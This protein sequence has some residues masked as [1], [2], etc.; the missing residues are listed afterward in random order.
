MLAYAEWELLT[1]FAAFLG[2]AEAAAWAALGFVWDVFESTTEAFG[3]A[4]EVR[5]SYQLGK[6]RPQ[7]ARLSSY[8]CMFMGL[9]MSIV[10]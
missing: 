9:T 3:D 7:L 4:G 6:G 5:V 1:V 10:M 8:K 2:P